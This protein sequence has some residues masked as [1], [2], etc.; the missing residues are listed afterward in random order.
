MTKL[1]ALLFSLTL[2]SGC[3]ISELHTTYGDVT[4]YWSPPLERAN[5]D[6]MD[7]GQIGGYEVRY[8]TANRSYYTAVV[9]TD[10]YT[11]QLRLEQIENPTETRF[12]VAVFDTDGIYSDFVTAR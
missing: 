11:S 4:L 9:I 3:Q 10:P 8:R 1:L 12:E 5:G 6:P 7:M 2:L